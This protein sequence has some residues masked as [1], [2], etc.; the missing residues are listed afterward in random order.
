MT[1]K[2][3][4]MN[5][6]NRCSYSHTRSPIVN[7]PVRS[8][9]VAATISRAS[10]LCAISGNRKPGSA[11]LRRRVHSCSIDS[12]HRA[13]AVCGPGLIGVEDCRLVNTSLPVVAAAAF[14]DGEPSTHA[15]HS[16]FG[17]PISELEL[18]IL[19]SLEIE[20]P[21]DESTQV[22]QVRHAAP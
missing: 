17:Q 13:L 19:R 8:V 15:L 2:R 14:V 20:P 1:A 21:D 22:S 11:L 16:P 3:A 9:S 18:Q 6:A 12:C 5:S 10:K 7:R 4:P